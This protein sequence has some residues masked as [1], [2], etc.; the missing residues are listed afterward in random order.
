VPPITAALERF[1]FDWDISSEPEN[2]GLFRL[3]TCQNC[4]GMSLV[5]VVALVLRRAFRLTNVW[6]ISGLEA[7]A[8]A[9]LKHVH[10]RWQIRARPAVLLPLRVWSSRLN[11]TT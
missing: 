8:T 5:D 4:E 11:R 2:V 6:T 1:E 10:G 7:R 9:A 3:A